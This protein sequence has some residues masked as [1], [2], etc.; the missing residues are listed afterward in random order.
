[1][2]LLHIVTDCFAEQHLRMLIFLFSTVY[3]LATADNFIKTL[4][5]RF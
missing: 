1:M 3:V 2:F 4:H 5:N